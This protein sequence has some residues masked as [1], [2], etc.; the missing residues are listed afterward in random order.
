MEKSNIK[1]KLQ[2]LTIAASLPFSVMQGRDAYK[3]RPIYMS[4]KSTKAGEPEGSITEAFEKVLQKQK[5]DVT[6]IFNEMKWP[7]YN[8]EPRN[9]KE[10]RLLEKQKRKK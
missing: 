6:E 3:N 2:F 10:R 8:S 5:D 9:R 4:E 1:T 7:T